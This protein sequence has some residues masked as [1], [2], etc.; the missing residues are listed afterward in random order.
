MGSKILSG[1]RA[2]S[3]GLIDDNVHVQNTAQLILE[4]QRANKDFE[5]MIYPLSRHG[6][7]GKHYQRLTVD[8]IRRTLG[9]PKEDGKNGVTKA[10]TAAQRSTQ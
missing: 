2:W 8:F 6:I 7:F 1:D 3:D 4:L 5:L 9:E 10:S